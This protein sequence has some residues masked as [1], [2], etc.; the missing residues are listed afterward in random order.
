MIGETSGNNTPPRYEYP[1]LGLPLRA[2]DQ[3]DH[4]FYP[5]GAHEA[6]R[7]SESDLIPVREL[8]AMDIMEKLTD[9]EN[10]HQKVFDED[11]VSKWRKEA[12]AVPD[13]HF[14]D[15]ATNAK[16]PWNHD[17]DDEDG[18]YENDRAERIALCRFRCK[19]EN[20]MDED[21][22]QTVSGVHYHD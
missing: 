14:W 11:V 5:I 15:L 19:L 6:C 20:I 4:G 12:L 17:N 22:F 21:T 1:G 2:H 13:K 3:S 16:R 7:A 18:D 10:W 9:K 8:A